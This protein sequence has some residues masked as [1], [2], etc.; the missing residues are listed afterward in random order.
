VELLRDLHVEAAVF[1]DFHQL[2]FFP[3]FQRR[4]AVGNFRECP[5]HGFGGRGNSEGLSG[6]RFSS[7]LAVMKTTESLIEQ[8]LR[9]GAGQRARLA[10]VGT[11][12]EE[13]GT[14]QLRAA[15]GGRDRNNQIHGCGL[16]VRQGEQAVEL[17][18]RTVAQPDRLVT[19]L[20]VRLGFRLSSRSRKVENVVAK[21]A[22]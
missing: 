21:P 5:L 9:M 6:A 8:A 19:E 10:H 22:L 13:Q 7:M 17:R 1:G 4:H 18:L 12:D 11:V 2:A 15:V 14:G 16:P 3:P 20:L